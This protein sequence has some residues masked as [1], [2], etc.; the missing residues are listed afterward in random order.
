MELHEL[1]TTIEREFL[2]TGLFE[3]SSVRHYPWTETYDTDRYLE[4]TQT[5][6]GHIA[7]PEPTRRRL[8]ADIAALIDRD[9]GGQVVKHQVAVLQLARRRDAQR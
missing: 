6:S 9:F 5:F 3:E 1:P 8:L 4:L 2:A 7:L